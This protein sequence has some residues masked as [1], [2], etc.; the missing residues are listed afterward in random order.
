MPW[1]SVVRSKCLHLSARGKVSFAGRRIYAAGHKRTLATVRFMAPKLAV[2]TL[3]VNMS[4]S[5][6]RQMSKGSQNARMQ[7]F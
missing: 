2:I 4:D 1:A 3:P 7:S 5:P 6:G